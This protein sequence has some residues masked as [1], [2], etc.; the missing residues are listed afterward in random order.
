LDVLELVAA[1]VRFSLK[2]RI[3]RGLGQQRDVLLLHHAKPHSVTLHVTLLV[4]TGDRLAAWTVTPR[5]REERDQT[6]PD[7]ASRTGYQD[8]FTHFGLLLFGALST[9]RVRR[10]PLQERR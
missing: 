4:V 9:V 2:L 6:P 1:R 10:G 7:L 3:I 5:R 8:G